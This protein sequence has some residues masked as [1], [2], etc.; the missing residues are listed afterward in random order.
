MEQAKSLHLRK[1]VGGGSRWR[2]DLILFLTLLSM[3]FGA[4]FRF[5]EIPEGR[6]ALILT[7]IVGGSVLF[8]FC[9]R[10][11][12]KAVRIPIRLEI[13]ETD[14]TILEAGSKVVLPWSAFSECL[15]SSDLFVLLDRPKRTFLVV[16]KRAFP[17]AD[18]QTWFCELATHAP[19]L[20]T[21]VS[22]EL[23]AT[24]LF[25]SANQITLTVRLKY[26]DHLACTLASWRTWGICL[27]LSGLVLGPFLFWAVNP[28]A[29]AVDPPMTQ[30]FSFIVPFLLVCVTMAVLLFSIARWRSQAKFTASQEIGL[31]EQSVTCSGTDGNAILPWAGFEYYK[32][33][34]W[35]F[36]F[37][38]G[39]RWIV[40]PKRAFSS[41]DDQRR[42]RDLL[43]QHLKYS[44]WFV[45]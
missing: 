22:S 6:R 45:G 23:P 14:L 31:S 15:E 29:A 16:P 36:I 1:Q 43:D 32:E 12:R 24:A 42:C 28:P 38:R 41:W 2:T 4:W 34:P 27:A 35:N 17:S 39:R 9:Q 18:W 30:F 11:F 25:I 3:L 8:V 5:R 40:L 10:R 37:W 21:P 33:T 7:A 44:R 20:A 26:R 13:S 19:S